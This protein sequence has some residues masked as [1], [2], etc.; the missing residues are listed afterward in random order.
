VRHHLLFIGLTLTY[1]SSAYGQ[2]PNC[3]DAQPNLSDVTS[4]A[5]DRMQEQ[6]DARGYTSCKATHQIISR[7]DWTPIEHALWSNSLY[8]NGNADALCDLRADLIS[9]ELDDQ[10]IISKKM[11]L[12]GP[13][14]PVFQPPDGYQA[15]Q[16]PQHVAVVVTIREENGDQKDEVIDPMFASAPLEVSQY[17]QL[18]AKPGI[19]PSAVKVRFLAQSVGSDDGRTFGLPPSSEGASSKPC[20]YSNLILD[21]AKQELTQARDTGPLAHEIEYLKLL[22]PSFKTAGDARKFYLDRYNHDPF[23]PTVSP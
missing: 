19:D 7:K 21:G 8:R 16:Y 14:M 15:I 12:T 20:R 1:C 4:A 18:M 13:L 6:L 3:P 10:G 23:H 22:R 17:V 5:E 9:K 2:T 11:I